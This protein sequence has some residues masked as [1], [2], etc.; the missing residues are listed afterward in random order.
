MD[1]ILMRYDTA[2]IAV[3]VQGTVLYISFR[4]GMELGQLESLKWP[5]HFRGFEITAL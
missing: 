3:A 4:P 2:V 5:E 1:W